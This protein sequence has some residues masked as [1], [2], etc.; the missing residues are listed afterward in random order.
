MSPGGLRVRLLAPDDASETAL[1]SRFF[2]RCATSFAQQTPAW[3][4]V[5]VGIGEDEPL[6]LGCFAEDELVGVLPAFRF[7]GP[8]GAVLNSVPQAGPLGGVACQGEIDAA[9]VY[10]SLLEAYLELAR[11]RDCALASVI[12]NP[13]W[14]DRDLHTPLG[15][16]FEL[17]NRCLVLDPHVSQ[18][19]R[20]FFV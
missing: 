4:R 7:E 3:S 9:P 15:A 19:L 20:M 12:T 6:T 16:D 11:E 5:I 10:A 13:L 14:P 18:R 2:A 1:Q 8:L 17:E